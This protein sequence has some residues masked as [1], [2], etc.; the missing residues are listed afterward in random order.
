MAYRER[1]LDRQASTGRPV[2]VGLVGAGQMG[3]GFVAQVR[4]IA[5]MEVVAVAD[6][7]VARATAALQSAGVENVT[8]GDDYDKLNSLVADGGTVATT[9]P[10]LLTALPVDM[11]IDATGVPEIG[12]QI[13]LRTLLAGKH[14]GLLNVETDITVG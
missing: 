14:V 1:L 12:A 6:L 11:V 10:H 13:A 9:D 4:R 2:R 3:R 5:G 8:S 7:D